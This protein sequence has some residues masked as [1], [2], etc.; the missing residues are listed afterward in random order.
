MWVAFFFCVKERENDRIRGR[1]RARA[2]AMERT[3]SGEDDGEV[4]AR[5]ERE[6]ELARRELGRAPCRDAL[7]HRVR[8]LQL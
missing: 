3:L 1:F 6:A 7:E 2:R 4:A 5:G 8:P